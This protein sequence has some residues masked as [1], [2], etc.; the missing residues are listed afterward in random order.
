MLFGSTLWLASC[1]STLGVP[2]ASVFSRHLLPALLVDAMNCTWR[3]R[4]L[5]SPSLV[6]ILTVGVVAATTAAR[7]VAAVEQPAG[8]ARPPLR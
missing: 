1:V 3:R 7:R 2:T 5:L 4:R 8:K 6:A